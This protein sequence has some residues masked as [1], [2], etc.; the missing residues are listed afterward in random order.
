MSVTI[1]R[2]PVWL[3]EPTAGSMYLLRTTNRGEI[4][5]FFA[6]FTNFYLLQH[7]DGHLGEMCF[8]NQNHVTT[9]HLLLSYLGQLKSWITPGHTG[10]QGEILPFYQFFLFLKST[11]SS[12]EVTF[13]VHKPGDQY[14]NCSLIKT[15]KHYIKYVVVSSNEGWKIFMLKKSGKFLFSKKIK[16]IIQLGIYQGPTQAFVAATAI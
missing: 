12:I 7:V 8:V 11:N 2:L 9:M 4:S 3:L 14:T 16:P 13:H 15:S 5:T 6:N 1:T 10:V